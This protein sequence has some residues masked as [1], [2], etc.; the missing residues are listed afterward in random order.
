MHTTLRRSAAALAV[1]AAF[2]AFNAY[3]ADDAVVVTA[4]RF[5]ERALDAPIGMTVITSEQIASHTARTLPELLSQEAGITVRDSTGSPD[6]QIDMRGF[7]VTGDQN[8]LVLLN[9]QRL[10]EIEL[11]SMRWSSIPMET[12]ERI[13]ILRGTGAVLYGGGATGGTINII[14]KGASAGVREGSIGV[15]RGSQNTRELRGSFNPGLERLGVLV[16]FN[17]YTSDNYRTNNRV[18][19][20]NFG[21]EV[22]ADGDKGHVELKFGAESQ[23][24]RLPGERTKAELDTDRSGTRRPGDYSSRDGH[25]ATLGGAMDLGFGEFAAELGYRDSVRAALLKD[26]TFGLFNTYTDTRTRVWSFTPRLKMPFQALG[27]ANSLVVGVDADDWD[28]DSRRAGSL[29]TLSSPVARVVSR[30]QNTAFYAQNQMALSAA[31]KLTLGYRRQRVDMSARDNVNPAAYANGAKVSS[32]QAWE[33]AVRHQ[34]TPATALYGRIGESFRV[35]TVDEV[36]SQFGGPVFDAIVTL[37]EPQESKDR[38]IGAEYR[39]GRLRA[40]ASAFSMRLENEIYFFFP[41]FSNINLPPTRRKGLEVDM[42]YELSP[43]LSL[44]GNASWTEARFRSGTLGGFDVA[45]K[46]IPMVPRQL[47]NAGVS[48]RI[49]ETLRMNGAVRHIGEQYYDNDQ[50]NTFPGRMPAYNVADVKLTHDRKDWAVSLS[51]NNI[52]NKQY[53]SY[54]IRN[55][56][57]TS[58]NA[59]PQADRTLLATLE[60]RMR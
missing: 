54:A 9:G 4:T 40:R 25:R 6:R 57:G 8:T 55:G 39:G 42:A 36:Y 19:Q 17:E 3:A 41:T 31:T 21:G 35:A 56:A 28:Y 1:F 49:S 13:E 5:P 15:A 58:F 20:F 22:R 51:A 38:E 26:Y 60:V 2:N 10:N 34:F 33:A 59:Y 32:P 18:E 50:L 24:L 27:K 29:E 11:T 47:A 45:G 43:Q 37:L 7:G 23:S 16:H 53:Y 44:F 46:H 12:I 48:W 14:T 30:Q 52:F